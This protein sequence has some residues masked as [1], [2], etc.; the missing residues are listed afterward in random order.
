MAMSVHSMIYQIC[1]VVSK[2]SQHHFISEK[3]KT[4]QSLHFLQDSPLLQ[5]HTSAV[6][7][8]VSETFLEAIL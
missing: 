7:V 2:C 8:K 6:T 1:M 5:L 3:Y 4:V